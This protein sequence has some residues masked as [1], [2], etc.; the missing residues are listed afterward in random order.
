MSDD[1]VQSL[2]GAEILV[3]GAAGFIGSHVCEQLCAAGA[4]VVALDDLSN[5]GLSNLQGNA[6]RN[7]R[8]V[9][10]D[11]GDRQLLNSLLPKAKAVVHL[12]A[13]VSVQQSFDDPADGFRRNAAVGAAVLSEA[14]RRHVPV[15]YASSA[16][17]YGSSEALPLTE[18]ARPEPLSPY[19]ADKLYL[20][21]SSQAWRVRGL[22]SIGLRLFN[23]YGPRQRADSPYSGVISKFAARLAADEACVIYGDGE[24]TRDFVHVTDV[25]RCFMHGLQRLLRPGAESEA[26]VFNCGTGKSISVNHLHSLMASQHGRADA[27]QRQAA[28]SGDVRHSLADISAVMHAMAWRPGIE[29]E[30]G[31]RTLTQT[32]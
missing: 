32:R 27:V 21:H 18:S 5:G 15:I 11:A 31:L 30:Q 9:E 19:A 28:N 22:R 4:N 17:V 10:G 7:L 14:A 16:A 20:E 8:F 1:S 6:I 2:A 29:L 3:T 24:Q 25:A 13:L 23:V 12:A 26:L